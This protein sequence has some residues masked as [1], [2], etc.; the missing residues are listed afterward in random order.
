MPASA[1]IT[2]KG[3]DGASYLMKTDK[4]LNMKAELTSWKA[5]VL[6]EMLYEQQPERFYQMVLEQTLVP[7]LNEICS[8]YYQQ[9]EEH[10]L[11]GMTEPEASEIEWPLLLL[12][13]GF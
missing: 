9:M 7:F 5:R 13:A 1:Y 11:H 8:L 6:W 12:K 4:L 3:L 2:M 10:L